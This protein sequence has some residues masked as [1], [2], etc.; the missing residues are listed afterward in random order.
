MIVYL[1]QQKHRKISRSYLL[2]DSN[3]VSYIFTSPEHFEEFQNLFPSQYFLIHP[4]IAFEFVRDAFI[5]EIYKRKI[6]FVD[7]SDY[8]IPLLDHPSAHKKDVENALVLSRIYAHKLKSEGRS[9]FPP[10]VDLLIAG[11]LMLYDNCYLITSDFRDFPIFIFNRVNLI[12][13]EDPKDNRFQFQILEFS[14]EK[15]KKCM[16]DLRKIASRREREK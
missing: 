9:N 15:Y 3:I 6:E 13:F 7:N 16:E 4:Y 1:D 10:L 5:P 14:K 11:R 12:T 2:L 8:F